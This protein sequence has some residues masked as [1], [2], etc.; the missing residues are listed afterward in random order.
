MVKSI[1]NGF[2]FVRYVLLGRVDEPLPWEQNRR[3]FLRRVNK[4]AYDE[5][6][7]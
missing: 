5:A 7:Y 1:F 6:V 2:P 3:F 4:D